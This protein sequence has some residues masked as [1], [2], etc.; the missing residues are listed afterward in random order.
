MLCG[1]GRIIGIMVFPFIETQLQILGLLVDTI[2]DAP[3][4]YTLIGLSR[5]I[6]LFRIEI[7]KK[8]LDHE[9]SCYRR[10]GIYRVLA[11]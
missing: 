5:R 11:R 3:L 2:P 4:S 7:Y 9:G 1:A 6:R 10:G 8:G